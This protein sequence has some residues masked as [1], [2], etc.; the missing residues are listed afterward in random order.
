MFLR[1]LATAAADAQLANPATHNVRDLQLLALVPDTG[2]H[3]RVRVDDDGQEHVLQSAKIQSSI[4][5]GDSR[6]GVLQ[7]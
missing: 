5:P 2:P 6:R 7:S 1:H 3:F 4:Q